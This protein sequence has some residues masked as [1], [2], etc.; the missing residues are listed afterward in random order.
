MSELHID[1]P[2]CGASFEVMVDGE[3]SSMMVFACAKCQ[4]PLMHFHGVTSELDREEFATLRKRLSKVID[5]A[6]KQNGELADVA[7]TLKELV[8]DSNHG[9]TEEALDSLQRDLDQMD[10]NSFIDSL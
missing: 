4:T 3:P 1:C 8:D 7:K 10:A 9:I 2:H 5:V 6:L